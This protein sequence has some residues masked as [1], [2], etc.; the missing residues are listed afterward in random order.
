MYLARN[1]SQEGGRGPDLLWISS[2]LDF[3]KVI[4]WVIQT[5]VKDRFKIKI[6]WKMMNKVTL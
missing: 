2:G 5:E 6:L 4:N 3:L 1:Q